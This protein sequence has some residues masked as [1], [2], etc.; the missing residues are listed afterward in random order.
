MLQTLNGRMQRT[1]NKDGIRTT[2]IE[3]LLDQNFEGK[4]VGLETFLSTLSALKFMPEYL[5]LD[6]NVVKNEEKEI[7]KAL[8]M[9]LS[10]VTN[11]IDLNDSAN[12]V[13]KFAN[14]VNWQQ[15]LVITFNYDLLLEKTLEQ[16]AQQEIRI[17]HLHGSLKDK[18]LAYPDF[19]KFAYRK[20]RDL[21]APR[22]KR[23]FEELRNHQN[24]RRIVFIGYSM[25]PSDFEA[26]SL[27]N[28]SDWYN[29]RA[30]YEIV[31]VNPDPAI[32]PNYGFLR[33][34]IRYHRMTLERYVVGSYAKS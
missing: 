34:S 22:W 8:R 30:K 16:G 13:R 14:Q 31:V 27:F 2:P 25:P 15:D 12:P 29:N 18:T 26:K 4:F 5:K 10:D 23:A 9:Y 33:K 28:Y 1:Q 21:F 20:R 11:S 7:R 19:R 17:L 3:S 32:L 24:L 6:T